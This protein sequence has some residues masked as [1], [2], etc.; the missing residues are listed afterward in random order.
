MQNLI[1]EKNVR[2]CVPYPFGIREPNCA[3]NEGFLLNCRNSSDSHPDDDLLFMAVHFISVLEGTLTLNIP[4]T[5]HCYNKAEC[6]MSHSHGSI[7]LEGPFGFWDQNKFTVIGCD[8]SARATDWN[9]IY[10]ASCVPLCS[11]NVNMTDDNPCSGSG[12]CQTSIRKGIKSLDFSLYSLS[13]NPEEYYS[14]V[15]VDW[16]IQNKTCEQAI[17]NISAYA[18]GNNTNCTYSD[19]GPGYRCFARKDLKETPTF[20]KVAKVN[21]CIDECKEPERSGDG[22]TGHCPGFSTIITIVVVTGMCDAAS[23]SLTCNSFQ[24]DEAHS[25]DVEAMISYKT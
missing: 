14:D 15:V 13:V 4:T 23:T 3:M 12:C 7:R 17:A 20:P 16:V 19:N 25:S 10:G 1:V 6:E 5:Y 18:Y 11:R 8:I 22:K 2:I 21:P 24:V 9:S